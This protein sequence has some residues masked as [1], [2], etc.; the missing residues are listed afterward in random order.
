MLDPG[1][2]VSDAP[3][4]LELAG[5]AGLV[6]IEINVKISLGLA[7]GH[8]GDPASL[9]LLTEASR[10]ALDAGLAIQTVPGYVNLVFVGAMLRRGAFVDEAARE[11]LA[12]FDVYQ[13]AIPG[14][15]VEVSPRARARSAGWHARAH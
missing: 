5:R 4:A 14:F 13:T 1:V 9:Q 8:R 7:R 3:R 11:A 2:A 15:A 10:Q 6:E 12:L